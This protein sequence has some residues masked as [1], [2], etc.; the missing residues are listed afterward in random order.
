VFKLNSTWIPTTTADQLRRKL[1][2]LDIYTCSCALDG[3]WQGVLDTAF[4]FETR[5]TLL[6][7]RRGRCLCQLPASGMDI[8]SI[9]RAELPTSWDNEITMR[10]VGNKQINMWWGRSDWHGHRDTHSTM[11][12]TTL[13]IM[14]HPTRWNTHTHTYTQH[15]ETHSLMKHT[16]R[17]N[18]HQC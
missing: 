1:P 12:H 7:G 16:T 9:A 8:P 11:Q 17:W 14:K 3:H 2:Y 13:Y 5:P 15:Y 6:H 18:T 4:D 10:V